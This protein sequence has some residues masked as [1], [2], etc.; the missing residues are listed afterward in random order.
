[1]LTISPEIVCYL[2]TKAHEF[3]AKEAVVIPEEPS[4]PSDDWALQVLAD[5]V[6]DLCLQEIR[7]IIEDMS[8]AQ[9][10]ELLALMWLGRGDYDIDEWAAAVEDAMEI[11]IE[12]PAEYLLAHPM[13]AD[14]LEE[15]LIQHDYSCDE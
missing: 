15:G 10:S 1:M 14:Y 5:H 8:P 2:V 3:Q 12:R 6:D 11:G 13:V 9:Q 7:S 4:S